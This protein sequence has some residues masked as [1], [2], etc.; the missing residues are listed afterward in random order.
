MVSAFV[1]ITTK[2]GRSEE[3]AQKLMR[4]QNIKHIETVQGEYD[5]IAEVD[6]KNELKLENIMHENIKRLKNVE[7]ISPL[8]I[9]ENIA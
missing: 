3:V 9:R 2:F 7:L 1:L 5:I 8:I 4:M 6:A